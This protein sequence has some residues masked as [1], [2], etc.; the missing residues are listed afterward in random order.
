M[1]ELDQSKA[2]PA[3]GKT[4]HT[5]GEW[6]ASGN[7]VHVYPN[8]SK[9][10]ACV[11]I[12]YDPFTLGRDVAHA[13]ADFIAL[14]CNAHDD[15]LGTLKGVEVDVANVENELNY[16]QTAAGYGEM[17][18]VLQGVLARVRAAIAKA[19]EK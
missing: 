15:L 7:A 2:G 19:T 1:G 16:R 18:D 13:N 4:A 9:F 12:A 14:A 11:C 17:I 8:G 6:K 10:G 5:P 3:T